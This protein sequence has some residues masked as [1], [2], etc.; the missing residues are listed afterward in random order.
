MTPS[1]PL[2][3]RR[4]SLHTVTL[5]T[6]AVVAL[7]AI[8]LPTFGSP[9]AQGVR[10][11][12]LTETPPIERLAKALDL[13]AA[14][15]AEVERLAGELRQSLAPIQESA[16]S[17]RADLR[18]AIERDDADPSEVGRLALDLRTARESAR[19]SIETFAANVEKILRPDQLG[20]FEEL[21][22]RRKER[23]EHLRE[24]LFGRA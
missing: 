14:Q 5:A 19:A 12:A 4:P 7:A 1:P 10:L 2:A 24:R 16:R 20:R 8:A 18:A 6:V 22:E 17:T 3:F 23:R 9:S 11:R 21:K 13:D 15:T